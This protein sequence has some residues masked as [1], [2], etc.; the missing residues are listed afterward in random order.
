MDRTE[1][2]RAWAKTL[3]YVGCDKLEEA[4]E[5]AQKLVDMLRE[6]GVEID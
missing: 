1:L 4:S 6:L 5:W 3:A 2:A